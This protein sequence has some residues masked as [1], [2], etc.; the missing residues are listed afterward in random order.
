MLFTQQKRL[1]TYR[2]TAEIHDRHTTSPIANTTVANMARP[3]L[4]RGLAKLVLRGYRQMEHPL[5]SQAPISR[6][7]K[8]KPILLSI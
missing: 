7:G 6:A 5:A 1:Q 8:C 4:E 3:T 2:H